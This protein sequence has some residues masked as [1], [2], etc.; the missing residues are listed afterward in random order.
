MK[1]KEMRDL[2]QEEL[3][4]QV[5]DA[6]KEIVSLR[7]AHSLRKLESTA[8]L[9]QTKKRLAQLL[10]VITEKSEKTEAKGSK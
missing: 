2:S 10:T 9:R 3:N 4:T 7:F 6:R 1:I 8:K 5:A